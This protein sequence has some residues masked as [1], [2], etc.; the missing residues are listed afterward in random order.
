VITVL[1]GLFL[2]ENSD[3]D[4]AEAVF[5]I[6][7]SDNGVAGTILIGPVHDNGVACGRDCSYL[8]T[9]TPM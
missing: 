3:N 7:N 6:K 4:V 8:I 5:T 1:R 9:M 2:Q